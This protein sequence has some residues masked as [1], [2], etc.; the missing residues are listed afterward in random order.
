[1]QEKCSVTTNNSTDNRE[2]SSSEAQTSRPMETTGPERNSTGLDCL[3]IVELSFIFVL[4][5]EKV[6]HG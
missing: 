6:G 1:M 5:C 4:I 3:K 2:N